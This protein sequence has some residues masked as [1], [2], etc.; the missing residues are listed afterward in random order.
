VRATLDAQN[1]VAKVETR[2]DN[3]ALTDLITESEYSEYA[4]HGEILY[5]ERGLPR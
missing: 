4:D 2:T 3:P 1:E 5:D